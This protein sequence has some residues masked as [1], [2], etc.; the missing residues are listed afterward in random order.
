MKRSRSKQESKESFPQKR[1]KTQDTS[2]S[3]KLQFTRPGKT[4]FTPLYK[5]HRAIMIKAGCDV[6][7]MIIVRRKIHAHPEGGFA[8]VVT[9][10]TVTDTLLSFGVEPKCIKQV[11]KT[12]LIVD[13]CGTGPKTSKTQGSV[14]TVALRADMDGLPMPENNKKLPYVS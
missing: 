6:D 14:R 2:I 1:K 7:S 11:A 3:N 9:R 10:Q 4:D 5:Q 13:I 12:G 8:E